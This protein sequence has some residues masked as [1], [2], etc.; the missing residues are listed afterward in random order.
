MS[1]PRESSGPETIKLRYLRLTSGLTEREAEVQ[2][3]IEGRTISLF[4]PL[5]KV[6]EKT[7]TVLLMTLEHQGESVLIEL[8]GEPLNTP[9]RL[10]V[11][12]QWLEG[13][14]VT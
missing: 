12:R 2:F 3:E 11:N 6:D 5:N 1:Q 14:L 13:A 7:G 10:Q 8:P 4:V 9:R